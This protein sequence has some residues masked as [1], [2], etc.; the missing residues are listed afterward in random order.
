[1]VEGSVEIG[2]DCIVAWDVFISDSNWHHIK[3]DVRMEPVVI[4][5]KVWIAHGAS[6]V[7]GAKI[8]SGCIVGAKSL[9]A[10][11]VFQENS[12][13]AGIPATVRRRNVQW[14]R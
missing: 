2:K 12:L 6:I 13:L 14:S 7:K 11:G 4:G 3:D 5:D 8:P 1:M 10:R 9:V